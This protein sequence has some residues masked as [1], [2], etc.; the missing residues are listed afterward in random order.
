MPGPRDAN[1]LL[2]IVPAGP[3]HLEEI[4][5]LADLVWRAHYPEIIGMAQT[6]FML[7]RMY[8]L[9]VLR[10]EMKRG[11]CYDRLFD[12]GELRAFAG[13]G[14]HNGS[15]EMKL[16]KLYVHPESQR[17]GYGSRLIQHVEAKARLGGFKVLILAVN[18]GNKR[19]IAAYRKN[20]FGIR[21]SVVC[22][23]GGGFVMDDFIMAK[24]LKD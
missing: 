8:D 13:Y 9:D 2:K 14:P 18:K 16:H 11:I 24:L 10:A 12:A 23:I 7:K 6:D 21:E 1:E 20:G 5:R 15:A 17:K 19:A 4:A 22:D 3:E